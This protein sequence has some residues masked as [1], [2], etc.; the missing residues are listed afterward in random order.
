M[1]T[2]TFDIPGPVLLTPRRFADARGWFAE[3]WNADR[4][5]AAIGEAVRF[6]QDNRSHSARPGTV[7]GL[8]YQSPP[9]AQG[10]LID[11]IR[12]AVM[13]VC[14]DAR[15]GSPSYGR[16]VRTRLDAATGQ[17]LWVPA[18]FLHGFATLEPDT[19]VSYKVTD[20]YAPDCEGTVAFD[21][22]E[23]AI[24]WGVGGQE[25]SLSDKDRDGIAFADWTSPFTFGDTE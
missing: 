17:Q 20:R 6:V 9:H 15:R 8:H 23:L 5:D 1:Q 2:Q 18:G 12:G 13:D 25:I 4:F 22:P 11:V 14:V 24:D 3:S 21:D 7:R 10:K 16:H 19:V